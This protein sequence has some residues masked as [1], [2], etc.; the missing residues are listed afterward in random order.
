MDGYLGTPRDMRAHQAAAKMVPPSPDASSSDSPATGPAREES[1]TQIA[2]DLATISANMMSKADK[3]DLLAEIRAVIR[4]EV[5]EGEG[6][7]RLKGKKKYTGKKNKKRNSS[8]NLLSQ[9][10]LILHFTRKVKKAL[11]CGS[12]KKD[13]RV[14]N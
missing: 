11:P 3:T 5:M 4:E 12:N 14:A 6:G 10:A 1:L 2:A 9:Q 7:G 8:D 13:N